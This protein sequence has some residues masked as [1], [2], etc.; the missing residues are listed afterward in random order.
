M[1]PKPGDILDLDVTALAYGGRGVARVDEFVVFVR[2]ALPGD[3]VRARVTKRKRRHAEART[4][5]LL[6]PSAE[7]IAPR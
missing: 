2:G 4:V 1:P 5:E 6:R 7:R 3:L